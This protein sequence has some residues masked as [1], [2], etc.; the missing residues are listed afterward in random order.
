MRFLFVHDSKFSGS[1]RKGGGAAAVEVGELR[2]SR[3]I[4]CLIN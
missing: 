4:W 1:V 2:V 3:A